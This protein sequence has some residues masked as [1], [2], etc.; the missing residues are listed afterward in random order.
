M[1]DTVDDLI[2]LIPIAITRCIGGKC[3]VCALSRNAS[4]TC[5][6]VSFRAQGLFDLLARMHGEMES[7]MQRKE[8]ILFPMMRSGGNR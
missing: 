4:S 2:D 1:P 3:P 5:M 7:H 6:W 8:Q